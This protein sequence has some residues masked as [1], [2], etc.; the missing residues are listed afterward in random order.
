MTTYNPRQQIELF[1]LLF[2][3]QLGRKMDKKLYALKGGCNMRFYFNSI[4]YSED[5][6]IDVHIMHKDTL[7]KNVSKILNAVPFKS[8][9]KSYGL[10]IQSTSAPKQTETTQRWKISLKSTDSTLPLNTKIE[11]SRRKSNDATHFEAISPQILKQYS[12]PP[13]MTTHYSL[14]SM[15]QQKILALAL[16]SETQSR[17][18]FDLYLLLNNGANPDKIDTETIKHLPAAKNNA[19]KIN[20]TDFKG[21]VLAYLPIEYQQ[22][23]DDESV[24][25][26][27]VNNVLQSLDDINP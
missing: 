9:L 13:I 1:H 4:R 25:K 23:Y 24:W 5:M 10:E 2:L 11:F 14:Q 12:L 15:Y 6:D 16:R 18:I 17:D 26:G 3:S 27:I 22:Q 8:I 21:Q 7:Y 20:F 19:E